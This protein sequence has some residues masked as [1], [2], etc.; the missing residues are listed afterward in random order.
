MSYAHTD[1]D[2]QALL[3]VYDEVLAVIAESV[4][5][6]TLKR[7]LRCETLVPLFKVR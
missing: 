4:E 1:E 2:V 7:N 5:Q 3:S 6:E